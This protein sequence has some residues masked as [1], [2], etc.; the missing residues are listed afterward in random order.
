ME[1]VHSKNQVDAYSSFI[2][3][4]ETKRDLQL[5]RKSHTGP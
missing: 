1:G 5:A 2:C 4:D 3:K